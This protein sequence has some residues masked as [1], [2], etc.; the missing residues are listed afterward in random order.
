MIRQIALTFILTIMLGT[1][2]ISSAQAQTVIRDS[3][4]EE[5]LNEWFAPIFEANNMDPKQV[6][7]ILVKSNDV[8][9]FVAGGAN[10]FFYT[11]L[12]Q[13]TDKPTELIGV[14]AHELGH[15]Q[16]GHLVRS[17]EALEQA[18]YESI[19][20]TLLGLGTAI[21]TGDGAAA[22][23]ISGGG[24]SMAERRFLSKARTFES[25]ADQAAIASLEKAGMNPEGLLT[26]LEKLEGEELVPASQQSEYVRTHPLTHNRVD[27]MERAVERSKYKDKPYPAHWDDQHER[28]K[29]KLLGFINPGQVMWV[30]D[31]NDKSLPARYAHTVAD[32][33]E[34]RIEKALSGI[35][36]LIAQEPQNPYF[37]ELKGQMLVDFSRVKEAI[38][39]YEKAVKLKPRDGLL[40]TA[41]AHAIIETAKSDK[42]KLKQAIDQLHSALIYEPRSTQIHRLLA[43]AY[44]RS[45]DDHR[46]RLHLAE[47]ALLQRKHPYAKQQAESALK[48]LKEGT[49]PWY[50]AKDILLHLE[51]RK[52]KS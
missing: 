49:S 45:G 26:F 4:I 32:Y 44:G 23:T 40:R 47:E 3:E 10:I 6:K 42:T 20:G 13:K 27:T 28:M 11:G 12:I 31:T 25:S 1:I 51:S 9:A 48:G 30:Y 33:R 50:R 29:A 22:A 34:S 15:I 2:V 35:D 5:I 21:A 37:H 43:T 39:S 36:Q 7:I 24:N 19:L 46:A 16:G 52:N 14:M 8:N 17:R 18:S 38:P 41:L